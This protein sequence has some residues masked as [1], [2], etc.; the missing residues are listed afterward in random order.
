VSPHSPLLHDVVD[1]T[2]ELDLLDADTLNDSVG[3][4]ST[5]M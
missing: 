3:P 4:L 1:S 2:N 5:P